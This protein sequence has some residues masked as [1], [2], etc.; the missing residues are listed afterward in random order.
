[1]IMRSLRQQLLII[2][3]LLLL[4]VV[5]G[6]V[7]FMLIEQW[8]AIDALYMTMITLSTVGFGEIQPLSDV[9]RLFTILLIILGV[10]VFAFAFSSVAENVLTA[11][12]GRRWTRRRALRQ[13]EKLRD[14]VI[15]CGYGRVGRSA[16]AALLETKKPV[17]VIEMEEEVLQ[18]L[19]ENADF[20]FLEGDATKDETLKQA[21]IDQAMGLIVCSGS[22]ADNLFIVLSARSLNP[23]LYI[24][25][26]SIEAAN[27]AK[28]KRAGADRVVSPYQIGGR[29]MA[30]IVARP[31][32]TEF[33][34]VVAFDS[35]LELWLEELIIG[36]ESPLA[37]QTVIEADIRRQTGVTLVALLRSPNHAPLTPDESTR[38]EIGDELIVL[39]TR[40]QLIKLERMAG[41]PVGHH[42]KAS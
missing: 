20:V 15:V 7:G 6:T 21:G 9:G 4:V 41:R 8:P 28:M 1:M 40:D 39:G 34:D 18:E 42:R 36:P 25:A 10:G 38:F 14:H 23:D 16:V 35:G 17:V 3:G 19:E 27:E 22:D 13:I 26:R 2:L 12:L 11:R 30:N 31:H 37:G 33:L 24:V 5:I 29:Q 32:V